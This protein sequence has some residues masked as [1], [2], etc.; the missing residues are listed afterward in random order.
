MS[1]EKL[2]VAWLSAGVSYQK[3]GR[4][5]IPAILNACSICP[6]TEDVI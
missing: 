3:A 5:I 1:K 6:L 2:K 4:L